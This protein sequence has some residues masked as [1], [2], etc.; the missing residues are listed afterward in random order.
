MPCILKIS[1]LTL[2]NESC[3]KSPL[4]MA[5]HYLSHWPPM[6]CGCLYCWDLGRTNSLTSARRG[7]GLGYIRIWATPPRRL[8][9]WDGVQV[10][11]IGIKA[12]P[13]T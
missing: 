9:F 7:D 8:V 2:A 11:S 3:H 13:R 12:I 6:P 4:A 1:F 5:S 10:L